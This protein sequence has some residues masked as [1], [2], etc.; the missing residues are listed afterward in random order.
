MCIFFFSRL[1]TTTHHN[2]KWFD[3]QL[4]SVV[5]QTVRIIWSLPF[6]LSMSRFRGSCS[7]ILIWLICANNLMIIYDIIG[8]LFSTPMPFQSMKNV[9]KNKIK[10]NKL[11]MAWAATLFSFNS[12]MYCEQSQSIECQINN[13]RQLKAENYYS[14]NSSLACSGANDCVE[15]NLVRKTRIWNEIFRNDKYLTVGICF[16]RT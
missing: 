4:N 1:N 13:A 15:R 6:K 10:R 11:R 2:S 7:Y 8:V 16:S 5:A 3:T 9:G 14:I 12:H